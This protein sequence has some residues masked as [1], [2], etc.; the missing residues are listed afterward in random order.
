MAE[1]IYRILVIN[2]GSTSTK[3]GVFDGATE[4]FTRNV[5]HEASKLAEFTSVSD[6]M[7]YR[8]DMILAALAENGVDLSTIDA[9]VGRGGGLLSL[10]G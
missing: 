7:P 6:Q 4:V 8:R 10:A 9:F 1:N 3:V 5:A 2:P